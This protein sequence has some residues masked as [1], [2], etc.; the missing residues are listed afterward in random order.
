MYL[1]ECKQTINAYLKHGVSVRIVVRHIAHVILVSECHSEGRRVVG[2]A[3]H[4][5]CGLGAPHVVVLV[6]AD[7]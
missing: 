1:F 5:P 4:T 6:V 2:L 7:F 3:P